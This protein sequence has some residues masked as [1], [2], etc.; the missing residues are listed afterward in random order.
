MSMHITGI[1]LF[2]HIVGMVCAKVR[3]RCSCISLLLIYLITMWVWHVLKLDSQRVYRKLNSA[4]NTYEKKIYLWELD[5]GKSVQTKEFIALF[6]CLYVTTNIPKLRSFQLRLLHRAVVLNSHL[7]RWGLRA[8]NRCTFCKQEKETIL[9][10]FVD[11]PNVRTMWENLATFV[12]ETTNC[13]MSITAEHII[14][15]RTVKDQKNVVNFLTLL[16]KQFIY[17][18]RCKGSVPNRM[19]I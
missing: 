13:N 7:Y 2:D 3:L 1:N 11:C 5:I 6:K 4:S 8:D 9:H 15:D 14:F 12:L 19:E 17:G 10:L 18:C 16:T